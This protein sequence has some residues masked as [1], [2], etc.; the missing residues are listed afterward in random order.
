MAAP[1][2]G[3]DG[4][5]AEGADDLKDGAGAGRTTPIGEGEGA[6]QGSIST[7]KVCGLGDSRPLR[8]ACRGVRLFL[9]CSR[10][11]VQSPSLYLCRLS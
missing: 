4:E 1:P 7:Q 11:C 6:D 5:A 3:G 9:L 10:V 8:E 2:R